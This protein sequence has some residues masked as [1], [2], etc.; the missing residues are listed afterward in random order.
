MRVMMHSD[1]M[2]HFDDE[3]TNVDRLMHII[4]I[5]NVIKQL[6]KANCAIAHGKRQQC[7]ER[8]PIQDGARIGI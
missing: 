6:H 8:H 4:C 3:R 1:V 7:I 2:G 5:S